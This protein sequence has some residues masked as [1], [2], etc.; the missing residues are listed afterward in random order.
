[1]SASGERHSVKLPSLRSKTL[2]SGICGNTTDT[3]VKLHEQIY[4]KMCIFLPHHACIS[5]PLTAPDE[6]M[7]VE[8][9]VC[10]TF[11]PDATKFQLADKRKGSHPL[12]AAALLRL[13]LRKGHLKCIRI[14]SIQ[15]PAAFLH[16][17]VGFAHLDVRRW[18]AICG[19]FENS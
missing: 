3:K 5:F 2:A 18:G 19:F 7:Q 13:S 4:M 9:G 8:L 10:Q 16:C 6:L 1:M 15:A 11:S 14:T 17:I 12:R